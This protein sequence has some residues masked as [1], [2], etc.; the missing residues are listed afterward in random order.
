MTIQNSISWHDLLDGFPPE[1]SLCLCQV[2][3]EEMAVTDY[4]ICFYGKKP[5]CLVGKRFW[6]FDLL[7]TNVERYAVLETDYNYFKR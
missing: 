2:S 7:I 6:M 5:G 1:N 4:R 3:H